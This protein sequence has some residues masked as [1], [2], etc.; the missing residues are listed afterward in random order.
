MNCIKL[1]TVLIFSLVLM[2]CGSGTATSTSAPAAS[3]LAMSFIPTK[4]FLFSWTAVSGATS[5]KLKEAITTGSGYTLVK[6]TAL[7]TFDH[8]VPIYARLNAKYIIESCNVG[9]CT[10]STAVFTST[11][12]SA[13]SSSIGYVKASNTDLNDFLGRD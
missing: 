6:E 5:Y 8:V 9:G 11:R 4:A 10:A 7:L 3:T 2:A 12:V 1:V 13:M